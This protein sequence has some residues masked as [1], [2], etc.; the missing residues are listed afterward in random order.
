MSHGGNK[1]YGYLRYPTKM[2]TTSIEKPIEYSSPQ[3]YGL[4]E[5]PPKKL[6]YTEKC[7]IEERRWKEWYQSQRYQTKRR[8]EEDTVSTVSN[9]SQETLETQMMNPFFWTEPLF[10]LFGM[11]PNRFYFASQIA[12]H[13]IRNRISEIDAAI[14]RYNLSREFERWGFFIQALK[15][16]KNFNGAFAIFGLMFHTYSDKSISQAI[17]AHFEEQLGDQNDSDPRWIAMMRNLMDNWKLITTNKAFEHLSTLISACVVMGFCEKEQTEFNVKGFKIILSDMRIIQAKAPD[18]M[19][20]CVDSFMFFVETGYACYKTGTLRP[21][22]YGSNEAQLLDEEYANVTI[23]WELV[24]NGNLMKVQGIDE[25]EFDANLEKLTTKIKNMREPKLVTF[26]QRVLSQKLQRLLEIKNDYVLHKISSGVR[27]APFVM[28]FFGKSSQ[29]KTTCAEQMVTGLCKSAGLPTGDEYRCSNNPGDKYMSTWATNKHTMIIDDMAN[30]KSNFVERAPT[31]LLIDVCNNTPM[32]ANMADLASKGKV[33][34]EPKLVVITTNKK[35]LDAGTYSNCPYSTQRRAHYIITVKAKDSVQLKD[36]DGRPRGI[37]PEKAATYPQVG[38]FDDIW[39]LTIEQAV[40][41]SHLATVATYEVVYWNGIKMKDVSF[42]LALNFLTEKHANHMKFQR[43]IV[44][45]KRGRSQDL[46]L[47]PVEG[48]CQLKATCLRHRLDHQVGES[49]QRLVRSPELRARYEQVRDFCNQETH[50]LRVP[51]AIIQNACFRKIRLAMQT[52]RMIKQF[53]AISLINY[54][55]LLGSLL[56]FFMTQNCWFLL[57]CLVAIFNQM[58]LKTTVI[59]NMEEE[60]ANEPVII[61]ITRDVKKKAIQATLAATGM[62]AVYKFF[63][64]FKETKLFEQGNLAPSGMEDIEERDAEKEIWSP[65][66]VRPLPLTPLQ[67]TI[68]DEQMINVLDNSQLYITMTNSKGQR[69]TSNAVFLE[70]SVL[71]LP[72]HYFAENEEWHIEARK[73]FPEK[74]GGKFKARLHRDLAIQIPGKDLC[75]VYC[76]SGG[77]YRNLTRFIPE[78]EPNQF[79]IKHVYR[80]AEGE[81]EINRGMAHKSTR[82]YSHEYKNLTCDTF[83]GMCGASI[84]AKGRGAMFAGIHVAGKTGSPHGASAM[85]TQKEYELAREELR[86]KPTVL[87]TGSGEYFRAEQMEKQVLINQEPPHDKSPVRYMPPDSQFSYHGNVT[88]RVSP[89]TDVKETIISK[90]VA[91]VTGVENVWGPPKMYPVYEPWQKAISN[92]AH[93]GKQFPPELLATACMD[94]EEQVSEEILRLELN[95]GVKPLNRHEMLNGIDGKRFVDKLNLNTSMGFPLTGAKTNHIEVNEDGERTFKKY[96][97]DELDMAEETYRRGE[98][99]FT[100][101]KGC[102]KDEILPIKKGKCR[103]FYANSLV[104]TLLGRKYFLPIARMLQ[105]IPLVSEMCIGVNCHGPEWEQL[106]QHMTRFGEDNIFGGDYSKYDQKQP[107]QTLLSNLRILINIAKLCDYSEEDIRVME[108]MCGDLVFLFVAMNGDLV[109]T[110]EGLFLSGTMITALLNSITNSINLRMAFYHYYPP[111]SFE[112][113]VRFKDVVAVGTYGDDNIGSSDP[114]YDK[115][116]IIGISEFLAKYD[117]IYT[118]PDKESEMTPRLPPDEAEFLKR[119]NVYCP[120]KEMSVGALDE[121]SI[122]KSLH[123]YIRTK[124]SPL[125]EEQACATNI[126]GALREWANHGEEIYEMRRQQML[127][128]ATRCEIE[129]LCT[130]IY[131]DYDQQVEKWKCKYIY[132]TE[133]PDQAQSFEFEDQVGDIQVVTPTSVAP[134]QPNMSVFMNQDMTRYANQGWTLKY[135][136]HMDNYIRGV[137]VEAPNERLIVLYEHDPLAFYVEEIRKKRYQFTVQYKSVKPHLRIRCILKSPNYFKVE[138]DYSGPVNIV[139]PEY[140]E[141]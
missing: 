12:Q 28:E 55:V 36:K 32:Y 135:M 48:C 34:I 21:L 3:M 23:Q 29:G 105:L 101:A 27:E 128:V 2:W 9:Q 8:D 109:S 5:E 71:L 87:I 11:N 50:F 31:Q 103:I 25:S 43:L 15:E 138:A 129:H 91:D 77:S 16:T 111:K 102:I 67:K 113:R 141:F 61:H 83:K 93:T 49:I 69:T 110:S 127:T 115:F 57:G 72:W 46:E 40:E 97:L 24:R 88:G 89:R 140:D 59:E 35:D 14:Q 107:T 90:V 122:F 1:Q 94:Y 45:K 7:V 54:T 100:I 64:W 80:N 70:T 81:L 75:I 131:K 108:A 92:A 65:V 132:K 79:E 13:R 104:A 117:Q 119:K 120:K 33:F 63:Q 78:E 19:N 41:P 96:V 6:S 20:A 133:E 51:D 39:R 136:L 85:L 130:E 10:N 112:E 118:M 52:P 44:E 38:G 99:Y 4:F 106:Y 125:T 139:V 66:T 53:V 123:N 30:T 17:S 18:F 42:Q 56:M 114:T 82:G 73:K 62:Y 124:S 76:A 74:C 84:V 95:K 60:L 121:D 98:R 58:S 22:M 137:I 26:E 37:D 116:N 134:V 47:C 126:D 86:Q 68:T